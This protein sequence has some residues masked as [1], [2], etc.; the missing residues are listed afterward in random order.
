MI[1]IYSWFCLFLR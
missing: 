1:F